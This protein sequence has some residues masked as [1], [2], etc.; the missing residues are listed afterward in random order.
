MSVAVL[1]LTASFVAVP[2]AARIVVNRRRTGE[3]GVRFTRA[4]GAAQRWAWAAV[5]AGGGLTGVLAPVAELAAPAGAAV[6]RG[7]PEFLLATLPVP[8]GLRLVGLALAVAG[9]VSTSAA[10]SAMGASWRIDVDPSRHTPLVT[11][12][13]FALVRNPVYTA[14]L[15][16]AT[17]QTLACPSAVSLTGLAVMTG[18]LQVLVRRVEEPYLARLHGDA[19]RDYTSHVGRFL[20]RLGTH[21]QLPANAA[22]R[23]A[24]SARGGGTGG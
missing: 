1:V 7:V 23:R 16:W 17:G 12:G 14:A 10:Q 2:L 3:L 8:A 11:G 18:A 20:P 24:E 22:Q 13:P 9:V 6:P 15:I 4:A 21:P 19:Y 5:V